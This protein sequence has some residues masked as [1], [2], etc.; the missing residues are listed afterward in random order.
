MKNLEGLENV[1]DV[2]MDF[3]EGFRNLS[4]ALFPNAR[5]TVDKFHALN[6]LTPA[7]NRR[8][9]FL[10][11][12]RRKNPI[13]QL[14]L[15]NPAHLGYFKRS[16]KELKLIYSFRNRIFALYNCRGMLR[17]EQALTHLLN[18]CFS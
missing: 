13:G 14:I 18:A 15:K 17:A 16:L 12:D 11:G 2:V 1:E 3:S 6:L 7:I 9:K 5:I 10:A 4:R 8:R